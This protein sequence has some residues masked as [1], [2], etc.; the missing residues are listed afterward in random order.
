ME[1]LNAIN[2]DATMNELAGEFCGLD[3]FEARKRVVA[4]LQ[5]LDLI[6]KIEDY[7]HN[8]GYSQRGGEQIEP[9]LSDQWFVKM[10]PLAAPALEVVKDGQ[11]KFHPAHWEKT[12]ENWLTNV[13]DWCISRQLWW[14]HR[15]PVYYAENGTFTA[16][17][18]DAEARQKLG[19]P[20]MLA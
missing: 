1:A 8:V 4:K 19:L 18:S 20:Q 14:G 12:Y 15:I 5:E 6:E 16:A 11:V 9:Y 7:T 2:P 13:R 10:E 3:R 17:R